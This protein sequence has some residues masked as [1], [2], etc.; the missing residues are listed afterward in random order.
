MPNFFIKI[1]RQI[2]IRKLSKQIYVN[3]LHETQEL[4]DQM[5]WPADFIFLHFWNQLWCRTLPSI[6]FNFLNISSRGEYLFLKHTADDSK[7]PS[8]LKCG[9]CSEN[10]EKI[11]FSGFTVVSSSSNS[12]FLFLLAVGLSLFSI[13]L[14]LVSFST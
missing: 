8:S 1:I 3:V 14:G 2:Y 7:C 4:H 9:C 11:P 5:R 10:E 12:Q 13:I 6:R